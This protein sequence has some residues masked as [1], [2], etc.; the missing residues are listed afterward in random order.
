LEKLLA[1][2]SYWIGVLSAAVALVMRLL[3]WLGVLAYQAP[4]PGKTQLT[5][6]AF[7]DGAILF[8]IMAIASGLATWAKERKA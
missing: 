1:T 5:Y 3:A 6:R 4:V 2:A 8:F 7:L